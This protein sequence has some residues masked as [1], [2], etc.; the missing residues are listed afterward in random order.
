MAFPARRRWLGGAAAGVVLALAGVAFVQWQQLR[1]LNEA[2]SAESDNIGFQSLQFES[3][4][5]GVRDRLR[6]A[7]WPVPARELDDLRERWELFVSRVDLME[8][9]SM[10]RR[11]AHYPDHQLLMG[12]IRAL[13]ADGDR[14]LPDGAPQ[15]VT[16]AALQDFRARIET[17]RHRVHDLM[18]K[19]TSLE[20]EQVG[21]RNAAVRRQNLIAI[22][23]TLF[24]ALLAVAVTWLAVRHF[25]R[26]QQRR[27]ELERL[28]LQLTRAREQAEQ[29]SQAKSEFLATM[30]HELRT[31][32][33]GMLGMIELAQDGPLD[34]QQ[35]RQL[36]AAASSAEH[37]LAL[38]N[39]I[40]DA[41]KL[42]ADALVLALVPTSPGQL[43][44]ELVQMVA[45]QARDKGLELAWHVDEQLP[46]W[47]QV[48]AMRLRQILL[49]L[50]TNALKFTERGRIDLN[51][52]VLPAPPGPVQ[53]PVIR[54][55]VA[56]TGIGMDADAVGRLF[57]RFS[58]ADASISRRFGGTGLGLEIS[59]RLARLMGGDIDV[60]STP[61]QG[62]VFTLWL[63]V[64]EAR[65]PAPAPGPVPAVSPPGLGSGLDVLVVDDHP[66]N[67]DFMEAVLVSLGH[68]PRCCDNGQRAIEAVRSRV[69]DVVFMDLHMP[70]MDG[71]QATRAL[72]ALHGPASRVPIVALSADAFA[73]TH[74]RALDEGMDEFLSKPVRRQELAMVLARLCPRAPAVDAGRIAAP[75]APPLA[76]LIDD[77]VVAELG[78]IFSG[79]ACQAMLGRFFADRAASYA[80]TLAALEAGAA[81]RWSAPAHALKGAAGTLG[82]MRLA[83]LAQRIEVDGAAW[84]PERARQEARLLQEAW[85]ATQQLC[86]VRGLL[87][88]TG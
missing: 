60:S 76:E 82:F 6:G 7:G 38:L 59:R 65:A 5:L 62:S 34:A 70:V 77:S 74:A 81:Q 19:V 69:P 73:Q 63:P 26:E 21:V 35:S 42:E 30:S 31:P 45:P 36:Q 37:L 3:E 46:A 39:D 79:P 22:G 17:L 23:L 4:F 88:E 51:V 1:L 87:D 2:V 52:S 56:D 58:Q 9:G 68:R 33:N 75:V 43:A 18:L 67:R 27:Q 47:V 29:A 48:D 78:E 28:N 14:F 86:A 20:S 71:W 49:N 80:S 72:R 12:D 8:Q 50:L 15:P 64:S 11:L 55:A 54:F 40:L 83:E 25:Q 61:G 13:V 66:V 16:Q 85:I 10:S 84:T 53:Q 57:E 41:S 44:Q 24:Q 32:F